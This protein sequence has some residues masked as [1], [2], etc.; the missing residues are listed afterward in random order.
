MRVTTK[1]VEPNGPKLDVL[2]PE[3][4]QASDLTLRSSTRPGSPLQQV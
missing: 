1:V 3:P 4:V 2:S